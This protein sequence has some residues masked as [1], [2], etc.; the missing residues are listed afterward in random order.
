MIELINQIR[1][2]FGFHQLKQEIKKQMRKNK[3]VSLDD[4][5]NIGIL[6]NIQNQNQLTEAEDIVKSLSGN[7]KKVKLLG[8]ISDK[9]LKLKS[10]IIDLI[11]LEDVEWNLIPKKDKIKNFVNNEFDILLNLC[12]E[13]CFPLVYITALSKSLFKVG[14]YDKKNSPFFDFML[15]TQQHSITGF[16][17]EL[18]YYLDKIK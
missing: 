18:K 8:F 12:T 3:S 14:A 1:L 15:A 6:V 2:R 11:S 5:K 4:A 10:N 13:I 7:N 16:T 9:S 17:T